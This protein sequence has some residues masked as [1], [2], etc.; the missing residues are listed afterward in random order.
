[1][2]MMITRTRG[3]PDQ[4]ST[5]VELSSITQFGY[6]ETQVNTLSILDNGP[7]AVSKVICALK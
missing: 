4:A 2:T 5:T 1:M 6:W 3:A 7:Q